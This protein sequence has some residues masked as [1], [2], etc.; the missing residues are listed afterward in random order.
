MMHFKTTP[1]VLSRVIMSPSGEHW[2][3]CRWAL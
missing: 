2:M 1:S 3:S